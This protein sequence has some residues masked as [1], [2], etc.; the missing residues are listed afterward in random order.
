MS[1]SRWSN[2]RWKLPPARPDRLLTLSQEPDPV[3]AVPEGTRSR[4]WPCGWR[5]AAAAWASRKRR[6]LSFAMVSPHAELLMRRCVRDA[7]ALAGEAGLDRL[8]EGIV[9]DPRRPWNGRGSHFLR[10]P[11]N[12]TPEGDDRYQLRAFFLK[13][14]QLIRDLARNVHGEVAATAVALTR[15]RMV[16]SRQLTLRECRRYAG[17]RDDRAAT[18]ALNADLHT[19]PLRGPDLRILAEALVRIEMR[20]DRWRKQSRN[21]TGPSARSGPRGQSWAA[22]Q[23]AG[24]SEEESGNQFIVSRIVQEAEDR[25]PGSNVGR[26][27]HAGRRRTAGRTCRDGRRGV[28]GATLAVPHVAPRRCG[29][30][31]QGGAR[32]HSGTPTSLSCRM[33]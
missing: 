11:Y 26:T 24:L 33:P 13:E 28:P 12:V 17:F 16:Q 5:S 32:D 6:C 3:P 7:F 23:F 14:R 2:L 25:F 15:E 20:G 1:V 18:G 9:G 31:G 19:L 30:S 27:R 4:M 8:L 29:R 22:G 21:A 10:A